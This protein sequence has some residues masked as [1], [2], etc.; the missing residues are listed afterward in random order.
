MVEYLKTKKGYFYKLKKNGEKKRIQQE[1]YNKKNKTIKN[2][3]IKNKKLIGGGK[4]EQEI[5]NELKTKGKYNEW[6]SLGSKFGLTSDTLK[7]KFFLVR[8]FMYYDVDGNIV[9]VSMVSNKYRHDVDNIAVFKQHV[10]EDPTH[11]D[12]SKY[13]IGNISEELSTSGLATCT[14]LAMII[15]TKK[16]MTHLDATTPIDPI[17]LAINQII[18]TERIVS[19]SLRPI[20]YAGDLD[21]SVTLE[22]AKDICLSLGIPEKNY[23]ILNVSMLDRVSI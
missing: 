6:V 5:I 20:I 19:G 11:V 4:T 1:E 22:K 14:G 21:S 18:T 8:P 9:N 7:A 3:T 17:I 10:V 23:K 15:G 2:K 13:R 16:F 12:Q